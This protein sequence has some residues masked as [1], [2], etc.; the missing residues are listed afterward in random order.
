MEIGIGALVLPR[1]RM[2]DVPIAKNREQGQKACHW[3]LAL[4][5]GTLGEAATLVINKLSAS[6]G[7]RIHAASRMAECVEMRCTPCDCGK[8]RHPTKR[9]SRPGLAGVVLFAAVETGD[10]VR[11]IRL[12]PVLWQGRGEDTP[13][14]FSTPRAVE[15]VKN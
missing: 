6:Q 13:K 3:S 15:P 5:A 10:G 11:T 14:S 1:G 4:E 12:G 8:W 2:P 9:P 7:E